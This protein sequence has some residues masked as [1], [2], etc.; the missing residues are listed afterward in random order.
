[1]STLKKKDNKC[2][3]KRDKSAVHLAVIQENYKV[4]NYRQ[5]QLHLFGVLNK[6]LN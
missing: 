4:Q 3:N 6:Q 2:P 1:M 5:V